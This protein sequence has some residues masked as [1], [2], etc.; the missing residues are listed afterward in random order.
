M[1]VSPDVHLFGLLKLGR[2]GKNAMRQPHFAA[3]FWSLS[4]SN[5]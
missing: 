2:G 3:E 4:L 1:S 5:L